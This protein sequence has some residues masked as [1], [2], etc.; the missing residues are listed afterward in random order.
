MEVLALGEH[1]IIIGNNPKEIPINW[2]MV[3]RFGGVLKEW[4]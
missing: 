1:N 4:D 2:V 3:T